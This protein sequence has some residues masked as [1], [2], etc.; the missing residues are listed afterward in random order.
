MPYLFNAFTTENNLK[1]HIHSKHFDEL[2][3]KDEG[4]YRTWTERNEENAIKE[5][6][7]GLENEDEVQNENGSYEQSAEEMDETE[8]RRVKNFA[9]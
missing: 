8:K 6:R 4:P 1:R 7:N 3:E 9:W 2:S 5:T